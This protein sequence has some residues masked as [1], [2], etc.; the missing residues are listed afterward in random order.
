MRKECILRRKQDHSIVIAD[1]YVLLT[2]NRRIY[3]NFEKIQKVI[4]RF[5]NKS[6]SIDKLNIED[7]YLKV[8]TK[9]TEY[10]IEDDP[11]SAVGGMWDVIGPLQFKFL[12][13]KGMQSDHKMLDIGCGSLRGGHHA[14]RYLNPGNYFGIDISSKAIEYSKE[15][16]IK[17]G[18]SDKDPHLTISQNMDL[19][20]REFLNE[21]FDFILAQS[22]FTHLK[23]EHITECFENI[24]QVMHKNSV[25]YFTYSKGKEYIQTGNFHFRYPFSFFESLA[26]KNAFRLS[27]CSEDYPHPR[28]QNMVELRKA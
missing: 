18:L 12:I 2:T 13:S 7:E 15:L 26:K 23:P 22:V 9:H 11:K 17:M 25:F 28:G 16:V 10:R 4:K 24:S 27:D 1:C 19:K 3:M 14:I 20:F 8:Y 21:K 6:T 5:F